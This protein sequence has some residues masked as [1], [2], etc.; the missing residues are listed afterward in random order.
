MITQSSNGR[1]RSQYSTS[2]KALAVVR[3][4]EKQCFGVTGMTNTSK[5][6]IV[7]KMKVIFT[8]RNTTYISSSE[9]KFR[10]VWELNP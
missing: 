5:R 3:E 10:P 2:I 4:I 9:N 7:V 6:E 1:Q 8:V